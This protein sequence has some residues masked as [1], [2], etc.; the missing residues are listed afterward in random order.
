[1]INGSK[2]ANA[3]ICQLVGIDDID[4]LSDGAHTFYELYHQRAVLFA[5]IVKQNK[6]RAW[7]SR[8]HCDSQALRDHPTGSS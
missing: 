1:M 5:A 4:D 3:A 6:D 2:E 8:R 7:K